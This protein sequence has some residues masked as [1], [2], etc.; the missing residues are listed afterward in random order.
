MLRKCVYGNFEPSRK[1]MLASGMS[2]VMNHT[3]I[4]DPLIV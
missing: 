3:M 2:C 4:E 1:Q